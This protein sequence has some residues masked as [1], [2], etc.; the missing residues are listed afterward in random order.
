MMASAVG[1]P[2][3]NLMEPPFPPLTAEA[4]QR[5]E[6]VFFEALKKSPDEREDF[7]N[8]ECGTDTRLRAEVDGLLRDHEKA[9]SFLSV[10][11]AGPAGARSGVRPR[12]DRRKPASRSAP[13]SCSS[14]SAKAA[15]A[16][17]G[18]PSRSSRCGG[19]VALKIIKLGHG[20]EGG[21]RALRAGAA[22]AGD[23]GSSE[24]RQGPRCRRD[25]IRAA[26]LRHGTGARH[27]DHRL[28]RPGEPPDRGA[29][30]ALHRRLPGGAARASERASSIATS[31]PRTSSSRCT[32]AC[33]CRRSSTSAWPRRRSSSGSPT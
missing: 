25:A 27:Q 15:S 17:S 28:L 33:R 6:V 8:E 20:H 18:W 32:T 3:S 1:K 2:H 16:W 11:S 14:R 9:G 19:R 23:D 21:D 26:V 13:T 10:G 31:S 22:G 30:P 24:H 5:A 29:A 12:Q 4:D 7:L